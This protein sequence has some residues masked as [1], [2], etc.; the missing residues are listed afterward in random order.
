[1]F[2]N[3]GLTAIAAL[4]LEKT[5]WLLVTAIDNL[6]SGH[7]VD[8]NEIQ[9]QL[10]THKRKPMGILIKDLQE[11]IELSTELLNILNK[12]KEKRNYIIHHFFIERVDVLINNPST[13]S[14]E[15]RPIRDFLL[16]TCSKIDSL[17]EKIIAEMHKPFDKIDPEIK[18]IL[19]HTQVKKEDKRGKGVRS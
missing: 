11:R 15:L 5:I 3:Y 1:M 9:K 12:A 8:I 10:K 2:A 6:G 13:L 19:K 7:V 18:E 14:N 16:D 17:L 4:R